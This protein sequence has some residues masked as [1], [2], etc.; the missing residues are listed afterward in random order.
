MTRAELLQ[1]L[2]AALLAQRR[3]HPLRVAIDGVDAAGKTTLADEL[4][5]HPRLAA[6]AIR[7]S[8]DG[9]HRP[10]AER[11]ARG[12]L[13]PEGFYRDSFDHARLIQAVLAPLG[14]DG[15]RRYRRRVF[16]FRRDA[17]IDEPPETAAD[18]AI[19]LL[20]GV[21]LLRPELRAHWDYRIFVEASFATTVA[22]ARSRDLALFGSEDEV[23]RRYTQRYVPGQRLYLAEARPTAIADAIIAN[24]D[25][26][27]P[28]LRFAA[29]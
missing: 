19:L 4:A 11:S 24:D 25:P 16:D 12:P 6:R 29:G 5:A 21:F 17:A 8:I 2:A 15:N 1:A 28:T 13:S 18:D 26:S 9:F 3:P 7:V 20:D 22:R 23:V 14:A 10:R 27:A